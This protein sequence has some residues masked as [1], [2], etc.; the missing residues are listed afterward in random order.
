MR[1]HV[2]TFPIT[3]RS[4]SS[5]VQWVQRIQNPMQRHCWP[6][7]PARKQLV[8]CVAHS[9]EE[10]K[11]DLNRC[12]IEGDRGYPGLSRDDQINFSLTPL[13]QEWETQNKYTNICKSRGCHS[14]A[15]APEVKEE[16]ARH[17]SSAIESGIYSYRHFQRQEEA[18]EFNSNW[19]GYAIFGRW[20]VSI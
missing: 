4:S 15:T 6:C 2:S 5:S 17:L 20:K 11:I 7:L 13:R 19:I 18:G 1:H 9:S 12:H 10:E 14:H 8:V 16:N 3:A